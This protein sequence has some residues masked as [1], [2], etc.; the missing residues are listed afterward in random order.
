MTTNFLEE[1][2]YYGFAKF[3][4]L[5]SNEDIKFFKEDILK[6]KDVEILNE[7]L[8]TQIKTGELETLRD[9]TR[10]GGKYLELIEDQ[11]L[12]LIVNSL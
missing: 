9:L 6:K 1:I 4:S 5:L 11:N 10:Y 12:N 2:N 7:G 8:D 3:N